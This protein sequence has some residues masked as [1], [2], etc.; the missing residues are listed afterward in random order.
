[1]TD[2]ERQQ[3][4]HEHHQNIGRSGGIRTAD[5]Q[6]KEF[7]QAIQKVGVLHRKGC[8]CTYEELLPSIDKEI[9]HQPDCRMEE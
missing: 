9:E 7:Y 6:G 4:I 8:T 3:I 2:E 1:M 5:K